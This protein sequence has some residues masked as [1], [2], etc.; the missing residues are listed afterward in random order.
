MFITVFLID[1]KV[2]TVVP[3]EF[4]YKLHEPNLWNV[5]VNTNQN[6][7][8]YFSKELFEIL[9]N[10]GAFD[11]T[12]FIPK[13]DIP[14]TDIYP[15]PVDVAETCFNARLKKFWGEYLNI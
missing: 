2:H 14:V 10:G 15:L 12:K 8:I 3:K 4:V 9:E 5:G 1:A 11:C 6:R 13:F 7:K